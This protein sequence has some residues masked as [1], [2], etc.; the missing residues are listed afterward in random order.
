MDM[1]TRVE[2]FKE[3]YKNS[4]I[5]QTFH[6]RG[7]PQQNGMTERTNKLTYK[8]ECCTQVVI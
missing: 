8:I 4:S 2:E 6:I 3:Y 7:T 5:T 1:S